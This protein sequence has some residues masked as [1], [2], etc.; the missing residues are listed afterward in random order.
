M[1]AQPQ[2][3]AANNANAM[4]SSLM[5]SPQRFSG[6]ARAQMCLVWYGGLIC[7]SSAQ[8]VRWR[9]G[10]S[11]GLVA[12]AKGCTAQWVKMLCLQEIGPPVGPTHQH[13]S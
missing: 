13:V 4:C 3:Y 6:G 10:V 5:G 11:W 7:P 12:D 8:S 1:I 2:M 9:K